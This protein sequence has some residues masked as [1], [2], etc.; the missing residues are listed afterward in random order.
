MPRIYHIQET[1]T[2]PARVAMD[3][4]P[5]LTIVGGPGGVEVSRFGK[6]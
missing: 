3:L 5:L 6:A 2:M 4:S 1:Y